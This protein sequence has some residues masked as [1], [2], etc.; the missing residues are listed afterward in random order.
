MLQRYFGEEFKYCDFY[1]DETPCCRTFPCTREGIHFSKNH[2][3][4]LSGRIVPGVPYLIQY[5]GLIPSAISD[6]ELH[7]RGG[8]EDTKEE[9]RTFATT[10][11][12][13]W[14]GFVEKW[15]DSK[16]S[17]E[18]LLVP[19]EDLVAKPD[20]TLRK[21]VSFF[22]PGAKPDK[23]RIANIVA[24][25]SSQNVTK[26][27]EEWKHN[28]GVKAARRVED[29]RFYDPVMFAEIEAIAQRQ[30]KVHEHKLSARGLNWLLRRASF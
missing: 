8:G 27:G 16:A 29:F 11:A 13:G 17:F 30:R 5:R 28:A 15:V 23:A 26:S 6:F 12:I 1:P 24:T 9:F 20:K 7:L 4:D 21:V 18:R 14:A 2:D 19:Y 10:R 22:A 3:F 25:E